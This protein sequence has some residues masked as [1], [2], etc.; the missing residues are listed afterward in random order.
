MYLYSW[1]YH[2]TL[3]GLILYTLCTNIWNAYLI[4]LGFN[5]WWIYLFAYTLNKYNQYKPYWTDLST[6]CLLLSS[7]DPLDIMVFVD[8]SHRGNLQWSYS[9]RC[10]LPIPVPG[11]E[12]F[13]G[14]FSHITILVSL[15]D[16]HLLHHICKIKYKIYWKFQ[17]YKYLRKEILCL[18]YKLWIYNKVTDIFAMGLHWYVTPVTRAPKL[19]LWW[20]LNLYIQ[21]AVLW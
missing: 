2:F 10:S 4:I 17:N 13:P 11:L 20:R 18:H 5:K 14:G 12:P 21:T 16:L 15:L 9:H 7:K 1:T 8:I 3:L 19:G 6:V